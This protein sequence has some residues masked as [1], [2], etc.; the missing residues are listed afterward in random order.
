MTFDQ[1]Y[2]TDDTF[3]QSP[4][5]QRLHYVRDGRD[6]VFTYKDPSKRP[7]MWLR[8]PK[9]YLRTTSWDGGIVLCDP[10]DGLDMPEITDRIANFADYQTQILFASDM[11]LTPCQGKGI[12]MTITFQVDSAKWMI[13]SVFK[14][15]TKPVCGN[16]TEILKRLK[17]D[18]EYIDEH[19]PG[20]STKT[21]VTRLI[22]PFGYCANP[23]IERQQA[24]DCYA[25][26]ARMV[27]EPLVFKSR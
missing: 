1:I 15:T 17:R 16:D 8:Y 24:I 7:R 14:T 26:E 3:T 2:L 4:I 13:L 25:F 22:L 5:S 9:A 23:D 11:S 18:A 10:L 21:S 20:N 19:K 6:L 27:L 12:D